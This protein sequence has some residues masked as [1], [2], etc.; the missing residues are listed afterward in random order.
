[1][2][3]D[4]KDNPLIVCKCGRKFRQHGIDR[5]GNKRTYTQCMTCFQ[6]DLKKQTEGFASVKDATESEDINF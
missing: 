6:E 4:N 1:M 3:D 2:N 5:N